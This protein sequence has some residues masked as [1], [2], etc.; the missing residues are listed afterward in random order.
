ME[1]KWFQILALCLVIREFEELLHLLDLNFAL[2]AKA[3]ISLCA[4]LDFN[5]Q[6]MLC[7]FS[8]IHFSQSCFMKMFNSYFLLL[9]SYSNLQ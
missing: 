8:M 3:N 9:F 2:A 1:F 4:L 5:S 7:Y 6:K